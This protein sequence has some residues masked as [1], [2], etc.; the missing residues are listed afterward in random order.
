MSVLE[1]ILRLVNHVIWQKIW[2]Y[3][4]HKYRTTINNINIIN[5]QKQQKTCFARVSNL[6]KW[7]LQRLVRQNKNIKQ[8]A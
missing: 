6:S 5:K 2:I 4:A 1:N 7:L 8:T 3:F